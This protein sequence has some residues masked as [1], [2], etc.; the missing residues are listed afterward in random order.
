M[1][2]ETIDFKLLDLRN[3]DRLLDLG[4]GEGRH[5]RQTRRYPAVTSVAL[6]LGE[7]EVRKTAEA[8][9]FLDDHPSW[10]ATAKEP[11]PWMVVRGSGYSLPFADGAFDCVIIS[12]VLEHLHDDDAAIEEIARIMKPGALLAVSVPRQGPE[13]VCWFLSK[14]YPM[15]PGGHIRIYRRDALRRKIESHGYSVVGRHFAH[16]LHSPYWWLKCL[17]GVDNEASKLVQHYHRFLVWDMMQRPMLTRV[18]ET[19]LS[20]V[21]GKSV[22]LYGVKN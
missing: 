13:T 14:D 4:C 10:E 5:V 17:V 18:L 16:G 3:G 19:L 21:I 15:Q 2:L 9:Q 1:S 22:V 20:P 11:G 6:D 8:L 7:K 12:E